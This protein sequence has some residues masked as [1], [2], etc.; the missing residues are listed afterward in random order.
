MDM[1]SFVTAKITEFRSF[2]IVN[3]G[4]SG[5]SIF[6]SPSKG[7]K[8]EKFDDHLVT[9]YQQENSIRPFF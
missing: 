7:S 1:F 6:A 3:N 8:C 2:K 4:L 5:E 9:D